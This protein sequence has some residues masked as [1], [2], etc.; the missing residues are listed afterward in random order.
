MERWLARPQQADLLARL[1]QGRIGWAVERL[2]DSAAWDDRERRLQDARQLPEQGAVDR[3]AYAEGLSRKAGDLQPTL[4]AWTS[5]WRDV[6]LAQ[7]GCVA[8][9]TNVDLAAEIDEAARHYTAADVRGFLARLEQAPDH[10]NRNVNSRLLLET[11]LLHMPAP[12]ATS[13]HL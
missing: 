7:H 2:T 11:L 1:S 10:L 12:A 9:V 6:L 4:V 8:H 5:W 3:L 13:N